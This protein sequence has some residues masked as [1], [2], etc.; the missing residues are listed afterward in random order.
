MVHRR[1]D[2]HPSYRR[3]CRR[4]RRIT[5]DH[6]R[7]RAGRQCHSCQAGV[8][9]VSQRHSVRPHLI[10]TPRPRSICIVGI[11][12]P[13]LVAFYRRLPSPRRS[14]IAPQQPKYL[15]RW[16]RQVLVP[17]GGSTGGHLIG[18]FQAVVAT[19]CILV[20]RSAV[21]RRHLPRLFAG[22]RWRSGKDQPRTLVMGDGLPSGCCLAGTFVRQSA[23]F[24][25]QVGL[26]APPACSSLFQHQ[27]LSV[28]Y[29]GRSR[30]VGAPAGQGWE[31]ARIT[32]I[33]PNAAWC[34][35]GL[36]QSQVKPATSGEIVRNVETNLSALS[37]YLS[38][39]TSGVPRRRWN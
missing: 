12:G 11:A 13:A 8:W 28:L 4:C 24:R 30:Q 37:A 39:S 22:G 14:P 15:R 21:N 26:D 7:A 19:G 32:S 29:A 5:G 35:P 34:L 18:I 27:R 1:A 16:R 36:S 38:R 33:R 9:G 20:H 25:W 31:L 3:S 6:R 17:H 2:V 10:A 23:H